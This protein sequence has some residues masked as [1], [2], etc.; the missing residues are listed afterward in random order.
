MPA[1]CCCLNLFFFIYFFIG[2]S[3]PKPSGISFK[4]KP[5][6]LCLI[7]LPFFL[8]SFLFTKSFSTRCCSVFGGL[9]FA[10]SKKK[11]FVSSRS[12]DHQSR[13]GR[14]SHSICPVKR[15]HIYTYIYIQEQQVSTNYKHWQNPPSP[16]PPT[17][18]SAALTTYHAPTFSPSS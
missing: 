16:P 17:S 7:S 18:S 14:K 5:S 2:P 10:C 13:I 4:T 9:S 8:P 11:H 1:V 6:N 15:R 12:H 3:P